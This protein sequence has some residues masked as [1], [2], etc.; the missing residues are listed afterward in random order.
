MQRFS[1]A[2]EMLVG[3]RPHTCP[4]RAYYEPLV[5]EVIALS[6]YVEKGNLGAVVGN[7]SPAILIDALTVYRSALNA[8]LSEDRRLRAEKAER[9]RAARAASRG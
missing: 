6:D 3:H 4:W 5:Q 8:T 9:E 7:D 1:A 2:I